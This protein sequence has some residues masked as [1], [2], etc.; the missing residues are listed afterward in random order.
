MQIPISEARAKLPQL[1]KQLREDPSLYYEITVHLR[2]WPNFG[3]R[4]RCHRA[5]RRQNSSWPLSSNCPQLRQ[6][7]R[8]ISQLASMRIYTQALMR[9]LIDVSRERYP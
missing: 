7:K 5:A 2:R 4:L 8:L 6:R 1:I 9:P 3:H